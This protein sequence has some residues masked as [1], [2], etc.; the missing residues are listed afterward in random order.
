MDPES[1]FL[2]IFNRLSNLIIKGVR[3]SLQRQLGSPFLRKT[4]AKLA[5]IQRSYL[6]NQRDFYIEDNI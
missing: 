4:N 1:T 3:R 5:W 2:F 6:K